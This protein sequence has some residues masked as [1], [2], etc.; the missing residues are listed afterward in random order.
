MFSLSLL[1]VAE[2]L[3]SLLTLHPI[4]MDKETEAQDTELINS[5]PGA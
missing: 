2:Q 1:I 4:F 3:D 5:Q